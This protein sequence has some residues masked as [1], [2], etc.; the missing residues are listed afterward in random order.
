MNIPHYWNPHQ[1]ERFLDA[2]AALVLRRARMAA[3]ITWRGPVC[4]PARPWLWSG[5]IST[6]RP[7][8]CCTAAAR[9][10]GNR[11]VPLHPDLASLFA[12]WP[13][14]YDPRDLVVGLTRRWSC[15]NC[16]L[17]S[18]M[19]I[20]TQSRAGPGARWQEL[21]ASSTVRPRHWLTTAGIP[22]NVVS[23]WL[24]HASPEVTLRT[25]LPIVGSAHSPADVP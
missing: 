23:P 25:Y 19:P 14:F 13:T 20:L 3:L 24:G 17:K 7:A 18:S 5:G 11:T 1:I 9:A 12:N 16:G 4:V 21:T 22:L 15:G 8:P 10:A 6:S 2:L